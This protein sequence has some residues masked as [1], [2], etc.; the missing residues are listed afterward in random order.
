MKISVVIITFNEEDRLEA[1]LKSVR[2]VADEIVIVDRHSTDD[3]AKLAKR[4]TDRFYRRD[5][6]NYADQKNFA[7]S[8]AGF[9]WILSIDADER[10]SSSLSQEILELK[11][12][13]PAVSAFSMPRQAYYLG[14]WIRHSD[15]YPDRKIR[16]FQKDQAHW[17]GAYVHESLEVIG[18]V[19]KLQGVLQH[20]TYRNISDHVWRLNAYAG[21]GAQKLY[22]EQKRCRWYHLWPL[23]FFGFLRA[24]VWKFGLLDGMAGFVIAVMQGYGIFL[25]YAKLREIW[26]KGE[27]IEPFP[28]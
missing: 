20:F 9:S 18:E 15:W 8:K 7:N 28:D 10:L 19:K 6:T 27:R 22:A 1:A 13:E 26:K 21:L 25:R 17:E 16:L 23:P 11:K 12:G 4:Y 3:T 5:W 24:Y 2:E 14:R